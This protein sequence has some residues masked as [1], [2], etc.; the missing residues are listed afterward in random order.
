MKHRNSHLLIGYWSRLRRGRE[1]PDQVDIDPRAI[2]RMLSN[3]FILDA[4]DLGR[5]AYRLA[6]TT[7]CDRFGLELRGTSFFAHWEAQARDTLTSLLKQSLALRQPVCLSAIGSTSQCAMMEMET[8]L[9]PLTFGPGEPQ[10]FLGM[11]QFLSDATSLC[12]RPI[13][14]ERLIGSTMIREQDPASPPLDPP[15]PPP[16]FELGRVAPKAPHLRLVVSRDEPATLHFQMD[17]T[18]RR[19]FAALDIVPAIRLVR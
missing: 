14:Y 15:M 16:P 3:V 13:A 5:P 11:L 8:V 17:T 6:G 9:A 19:M 12:G 4:R 1:A 18:M 10:R 2:K 7:L